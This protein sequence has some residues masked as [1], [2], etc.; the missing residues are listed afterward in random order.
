MAEHHAT[1][2]WNMSHVRNTCSLGMDLAVLLQAS[3]ATALVGYLL[4]ES[5]SKLLLLLVRVSSVVWQDDGYEYVVH[6]GCQN[7]GGLSSMNDV[8]HQSNTCRFWTR[9]IVLLVE[10]KKNTWRI[11]RRQSSAF[12]D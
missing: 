11:V 1:V 10:P 9:Q 3:Q 7:H 2:R 5:D 4:A 6:A 12:G 8:V